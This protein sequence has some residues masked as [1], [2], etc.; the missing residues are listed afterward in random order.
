M[1]KSTDAE[2][3]AWNAQTT[4]TTAAL[5]VAGGI[6]VQIYVGGP[7]TNVPLAVSFDDF[8]VHPVTN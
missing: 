6:G 5:Q 4:D 3:V 7:V 1:W 2:P 8:I